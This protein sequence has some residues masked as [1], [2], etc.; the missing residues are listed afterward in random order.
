[1]EIFS[2]IKILKKTKTQNLFFFDEKLKRKKK[3]AISMLILNI[4]LFKYD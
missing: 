1:M 3:L 2:N 4:T